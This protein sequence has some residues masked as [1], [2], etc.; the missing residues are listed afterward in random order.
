MTNVYIMLAEGNE[1]PSWYNGKDKT[2]MVVPL[3]DRRREDIYKGNGKYIGRDK[4]QYFFLE[5][6][7]LTRDGDQLV[8]VLLTKCTPR[9]NKKREPGN[10]THIAFTYEIYAPIIQ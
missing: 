1:L 9:I 8:L 3:S 6:I 7:G 2:M 5:E 4:K 10:Y